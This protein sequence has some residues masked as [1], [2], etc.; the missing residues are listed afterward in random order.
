MNTILKYFG[1]PGDRLCTRMLPVLMFSSALAMTLLIARIELTSSR[2]FLFLAWNLFLAW[3]PYALSFALQKDLI[4]PWWMRAGIF[5]MWLLF[6]PNAPYILTDLL[7]LHPREGMPLWFDLLLLLS[8][9]WTGLMLGLA[10]LLNVHEFFRENMSSLKAW[11]LVLAIALLCGF[12][13]YLGRFLRWNSWDAFVNPGPILRTSWNILSDPFGNMKAT[14]F[15][16]IFSGFLVVSYLT[17][18]VLVR[19]HEKRTG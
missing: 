8:F 10:S 4:I 13:I 18:L 7:H 9:A 5:I 16:L 14:G 6:F 12:G 2:A 17:L 3:I 19:P 15:T 11:L 1:L